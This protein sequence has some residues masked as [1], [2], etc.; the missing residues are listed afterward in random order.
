MDAL[1]GFYEVSEEM[2]KRL[3]QKGED[4]TQEGAAK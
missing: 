1:K 3:M 2:E 4:L